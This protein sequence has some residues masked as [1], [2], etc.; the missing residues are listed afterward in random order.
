MINRHKIHNI[1][2]YIKLFDFEY[3]VIEVIENLNNILS[4]YDL[5][6]M[7]LTSEEYSI[8]QN[9]LIPLA[10]NFE[11]TEVSRLTLPEAESL[12]CPI[13]ALI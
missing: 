2:E 1:V 13:E 7:A 10:E 3:E 4:S 8:L 5:L 6:D 12:M 9:E 11:F